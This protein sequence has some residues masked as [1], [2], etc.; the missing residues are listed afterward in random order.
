MNIREFIGQNNCLTP[1]E[2]RLC[3]NEAKENVV[4]QND[5]LKVNMVLELENRIE[6]ALNFFKKDE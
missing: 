3:L 1:Q 6:E 2:E 4:F 5:D